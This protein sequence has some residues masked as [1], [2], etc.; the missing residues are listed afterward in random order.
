MLRRSPATSEVAI[1]AL[2]IGI[3]ANTNMF[4]WVE[5]VL[6]KPLPFED[7]DRLVR[8]YDTEP[9]HGFTNNMVS[10][11]DF[12][13][14]KEQSRSI[15]NMS[16]FGFWDA[17]LTGIDDPERLQG[18]SV[19][20]DFFRALGMP[21]L[22]GRTFSASEEIPGRDQAVII[23]HGLWQRRSGGDSS[24]I[25]KRISLNELQYVV[26]G[27]MPR[28]FDFPLG[29]DVW[30]PPAP[31]PV[32]KARRDGRSLF[33]LGRLKHDVSL[34]QANAQIKIIAAR[35]A[36]QYPDTNGGHA[37]GVQRLRDVLNLV[38]D[39]FVA[40]LTGAAAFI[41]LLICSNVASIQLARMNSRVRELAM[42]SALGAGHWRIARQLIT[43]NILLAFLGGILGVAL[44]YWEW[45]LAK[46]GIPPQV[47]K[48][49]A[50]LRNVRIDGTALVFSAATALLTGVLCG[51]VPAFQ[52]ARRGDLNEALKDGGR[53]FSE[54]NGRS[55]RQVLVV[56]EV[57]MAL[58]MLISA[59]SLVKTFQHMMKF[60]LGFNPK[61]LLTMQVALTPAR[62]KE[63]ASSRAYYDQAIANLRRV[64]EVVAAG[65]S[66]NTAVMTEFRAEGQ[67]PPQPG[68]RL[69]E[70]QFVS[71]DYFTAMGIAIKR[72]R[73]L[74]SHDEGT[75]PAPVAVVSESTVRR[76]W[77]SAEDA[78][79]ATI[80]IAPYNLPPLTVVGVAGDVKDR[81]TGMGES[82]AYISSAH[83]P[84]R[85]MEIVV[86]TG[87]DPVKV[88]AEARAQL[89]AVYRNQP[90]Y[91]IKSMEQILDEQTSGVRIAAVTMSG[92]GIIA[93]FLAVIGTYGIDTC[94]ENCISN[95][96]NKFECTQD[97][98]P[99]ED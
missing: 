48:W 54:P 52:A 29:T 18:Y 4:T 2:A 28:D 58:V 94:G 34:A 17:N 90:M 57:A 40:I 21:P 92:S 73:A 27:V 87:A 88:V 39:R 69:P 99:S 36:A 25:G 10:V 64:P 97:V 72:G 62:Y 95:E 93:L 6:L 26:V 86:R 98:R 47:C 96:F 46:P 5:A 76:L 77:R 12:A 61:S 30:K 85:S 22:L 15:E 91:D 9:K 37:A 19:S 74:S 63:S 66:A 50:G 49:V 45:N 44:G 65:S 24:I 8:L 70:L 42:R 79:G 43:E 67:A 82:A 89:Q 20:S 80:H 81:F 3:A 23:S 68:E 55:V 83:M 14:W 78:V 32:E 56:C 38:T 51:Q 31:P 53:G 33:V 41:L 1:T 59:G 35:L 71:G 7:L 16:A 60:D 84:Q 11:A 13:D 75:P